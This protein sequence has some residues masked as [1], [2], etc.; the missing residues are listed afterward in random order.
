MK[1]HENS[2]KV[3]EMIIKKG[4]GQILEYL[5]EIVGTEEAYKYADEI[6]SELEFHDF[7]VTRGTAEGHTIAMI[8]PDGRKY[9]IDMAEKD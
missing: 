8:R 5:K 2:K 4:T 1:L 3:L 6:T 7:I 9:L